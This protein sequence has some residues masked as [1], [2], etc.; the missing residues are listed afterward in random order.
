MN[1]TSAFGF[2]T[3]NT[4]CVRLRASRQRV[5]VEASRASS[6]RVMVIASVLPV[7]EGKSP[8]DGPNGPLKRVAPGDILGVWRGGPFFRPPYG[9]PDRVGHSVDGQGFECSLVSLYGTGGEREGAVTIPHRVRGADGRRQALMGGLSQ[10]VG[11]LLGECRI[12]GHHEEC[13]VR[14]RCKRRVRAE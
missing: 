2:P 4:T 14:W 13:R 3:P 8:T 9:S 7:I 5:Q 11:T 6:W 10:Q 1:I 12:G